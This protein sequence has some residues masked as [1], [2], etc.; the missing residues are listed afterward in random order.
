MAIGI[1]GLVSGLDTESIISQMMNLERRPVQLLQG[2]EADFQAKLSALGTMRGG[3]AALQTAA[4][5]LGDADNFVSFGAISGNSTVLSVTADTTA[6]AGTYQVEVGALA[7]AQQVRSAAF[8]TADE[9]VGTGTLTIQVGDNTAVDVAIDE[10]HQSLAGIAQAINAAGTDVSAAVVDDGNGN[11]YLTL[12]SSQTGAANTISLT[13]ADDDGTNTDGAGLSALYEVPADQAMFETQAAVSAQLT[14]NGVAVERAGNTIDDLIAGVTLTLNEVDPGN[15]FEVTVSQDFSVIT[16]KVE[17]FVKQYNAMVGS[18]TT[19]QSYNADAGTGGIL[20]G[21][22]TTRQL[23]SSLQ[24]LL[25]GSV[26]GVADEVNGFSRLG[27]EVGRDGKLVLDSE[28]L[29]TAVADNTDDVIR[30]FS[31]DEAGN[32]GM[33]RRFDELL[34]GYLNK[35]FG[36]IDSKEDG[37]RSSI[38]SINDQVDRIEYRLG[39]KE[40][41]LRQ[42]FL[43]LESLLAG[44]QATQGALDQQLQSL[45]NLSTYISTKK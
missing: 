33:G 20:Q 39:K 45:A 36:V 41:H 18:F 34:E 38:E 44:L 15:P 28:K 31:N 12:A 6:L 35:S 10:E 26:E 17:S 24:G 7:S 3:L 21:D 27:I 2:R 4:A 22:S 19:L 37:L 43:N 40:A 9:P 29:A 13:M 5:S 16:K 32:K 42:Q 8:A 14:L 23:R 11:F 25:Y 30:F 1:N